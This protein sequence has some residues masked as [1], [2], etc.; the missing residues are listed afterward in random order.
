[1][2]CG[3]Q[4]LRSMPATRPGQPH[5]PDPLAR[6]TAKQDQEPQEVTQ[7][8]RARA[9]VRPPGRERSYHATRAAAHPGTAI[10]HQVRLPSDNIMRR[11]PRPT[12]KTTRT[13]AERSSLRRSGQQ[14]PNPPHHRLSDQHLLGVKGSRPLLSLPARPK[15]AGQG[16]A[17]AVGGGSCRPA[18]L[19]QL[20]RA[21]DPEPAIRQRGRS[22][23]GS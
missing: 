3:A 10:A 21:L 2:R 12:A 6:E 14:I 22:R 8:R 17:G 19:G 23:R 13:L 20:K 5:E 15:G 18:S 16:D 9:V 1:M 7:I 4:A 11:R